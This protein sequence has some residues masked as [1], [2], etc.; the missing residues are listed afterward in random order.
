[1]PRMAE[2]EARLTEEKK[3][4]STLYIRSTQSELRQV[5]PAAPVSGSSIQ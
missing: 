3:E 1:M 2:P 5:E 4:P